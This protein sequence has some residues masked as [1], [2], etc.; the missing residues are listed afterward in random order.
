[1]DFLLSYQRIYHVF[2]PNSVLEKVSAARF[3][4][5]RRDNRTPDR[6]GLPVRT[7]DGVIGVAQI[8]PTIE[9]ARF[10]NADAAHRE[11]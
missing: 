5:R 4:E 6:A 1:M 9:F 8:G 10:D 7:L 11:F 2:P 3:P